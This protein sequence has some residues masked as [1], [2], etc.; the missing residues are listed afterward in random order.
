MSAGPRS[1]TLQARPFLVLRESPLAQGTLSRGIS[2]VSSASPVSGLR[3]MC[4]LKTQKYHNDTSGSKYPKHVSEICKT[5][6]PV[7]R[8]GLGAVSHPFRTRC[9]D[10][11]P[12]CAFRSELKSLH[13][14]KKQ[15]NHK[16]AHQTEFPKQC[17]GNLRTPRHP[18]S[19][20][21]RGLYSSHCRLYAA[22]HNVHICRSPHAFHHHS[23]R[24]KGRLFR[25]AGH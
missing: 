10:F 13:A 9:S 5:A 22:C 1:E 18:H 7:S 12:A 6:S 24:T 17:F 25:S 14:L 19:A 15:E 4:V 3:G 8:T 21:P 16:S 20:K 11:L 2:F 23:R